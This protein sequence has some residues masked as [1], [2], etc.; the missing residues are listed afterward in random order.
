MWP[1]LNDDG[2]I[3]APARA[4]TDGVIGDGVLVLSPGDDGYAAAAAEIER[5]REILES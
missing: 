5:H 3:T 2:T 1:V 4:E